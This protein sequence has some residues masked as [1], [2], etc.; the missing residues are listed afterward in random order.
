MNANQIIVAVLA[1]FVVLA[2]LDR[3]IGNR[4]GLAGELERAFEMLGIMGLNVVG[5]VCM[6][7]VIAG[8]L[9]P[10][11]V[12]AFS[13]LGADPALFS[14]CILSPDCGGYS[15]AAELSDDPEMVRFGGLLV[16]AILGG[17]VAFAIPVCCGLLKGEDLRYFAV[18]V[19]AAFAVAPITCL[20]AG[21][22][23]GLSPVKTLKNLVP[24]ILL[25]ALIVVGLALIPQRMIRGFQL[26]A[27]GLGVVVMAGLALGAVEAMTGLVILPGM[28]PVEDGFLIIGSVTITMA[29]A[30]PLIYFVTR[31][32][33]RPLNAVGSRLGMN[34]TSLVSI[35]ICTVTFVPAI[36]SYEKLNAREKVL[37]AAAIATVG[38]M[39]GAHLGFIAMTDQEMILP[40]VGAK[41]VGG[42]LALPLSALLGRRL[43]REVWRKRGEER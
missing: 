9:Q 14:G 31:A 41:V 40:M 38:N 8:V 19:L 23:M 4:L 22:M 42:V 10:V 17:V 43:F 12:P 6:A 15:I 16:A 27:R 13:A 30:L 28:N 5:L 34:D 29:G 25:A 20:T 24:V 32:G 2:T 26:F 35:L 3:C 21:L 39:A 33:K 18:G 36:L 1:V 37:L 11:V 7:P